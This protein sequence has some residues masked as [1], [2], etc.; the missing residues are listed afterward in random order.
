MV[1]FLDRLTQCTLGVTIAGLPLGALIGAVLATAALELNVQ[2]LVTFDA[3]LNAFDVS[4]SGYIAAI[5]VIYVY[6]LVIDWLI[7][8]HGISTYWRKLQNDGRRCPSCQDTCQRMYPCAHCYDHAGGAGSCC[9]GVCGSV[10]ARCILWC[11]C[12]LGATFYACVGTV[13]LWLGFFVILLQIVASVTIGIIFL[14]ILSTCP[15]ATKFVS[16]HLD[17]ANRTAQEIRNFFHTSG[18]KVG[19]EAVARPPVSIDLVAAVERFLAEA[20]TCKP[21]VSYHIRVT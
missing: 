12:C 21:N 2:G 18:V 15:E 9:A 20:G 14:G 16:E 7:V 10:Y 1:S 8:T 3:G 19:L 13:L 11:G 4:I 5:T 6:V 17:L